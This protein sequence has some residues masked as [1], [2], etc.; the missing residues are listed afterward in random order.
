M[1]QLSP[2]LEFPGW[3]ALM[4]ARKAKG[5]RGGA[6]PGAGRPTVVHDPV[7]FTLDF[8][9]PD[10]EALE[11]IAEEKGKSI[12]ALVRAAVATFVKRRRR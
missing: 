7:R 2:P 12:A 6:R 5:K 8:E 1:I 11:G 10:F 3:L 4:A 9:R